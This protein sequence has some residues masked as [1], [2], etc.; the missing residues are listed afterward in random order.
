NAP[1]LLR[2]REP[3]AHPV[4]ETVVEQATYAFYIKSRGS[5]SAQDQWVPY[6]EDAVQSD[7]WNLWHTNF[8]DNLWIEVIDEPYDNGIVGKHVVYHIEERARL[9]AVDYAP[10]TGTKMKVEVSKIE[11]T[12][13]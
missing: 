9:K 5:I 13:K 12:L 11:E 6:Q 3:V 8:L 7:F 10:A 1:A 4:N 2:C